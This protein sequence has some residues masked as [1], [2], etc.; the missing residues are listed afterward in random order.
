MAA[1]KILSVD[2]EEEIEFL[3][4]QYFRRKMRSGEYEFFFAH[5]GVEGLTMLYDHPDIDIILCDL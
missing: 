4:K 3:M 5:N 1:I 2:D